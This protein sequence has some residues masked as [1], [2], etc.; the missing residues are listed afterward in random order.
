[1]QGRNGIA[2]RVHIPQ[3]KNTEKIHIL[4][5]PRLSI[6]PIPSFLINPKHVNEACTDHSHH[7]FMAFVSS[8][9]LIAQEHISERKELAQSPLENRLWKREKIKYISDPHL[10]SKTPKF[11]HMWIP[12]VSSASAALC[13]HRNIKPC[14]LTKQKLRCVCWTNAI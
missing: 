13:A 14:W 8:A 1:M 9:W 5:K 11:P 12:K 7:D 6:V 10:V 3:N 4:L 2:Y